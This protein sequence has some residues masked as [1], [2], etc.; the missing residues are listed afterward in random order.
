MTW[1]NPNN[2]PDRR[3][4]IDREQHP[5]WTGRTYPEAEALEWFNALPM[6]QVYGLSDEQ[7]API[8]ASLVK[9]FRAIHFGEQYPDVWQEP[10]QPAPNVLTFE[11]SSSNQPLGSTLPVPFIEQPDYTTLLKRP[12]TG[13]LTN[14]FFRPQTDQLNSPQTVSINQK[15]TNQT[16]KNPT[17]QSNN[18]SNQQKPLKKIS[19]QY[20]ILDLL[21]PS[22]LQ[23]KAKTSNVEMNK[24]G[25]FRGVPPE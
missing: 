14:S 3:R 12:D 18:T 17:R 24:T 11:T 8:A 2:P 25:L 4:S 5:A 21:T 10:K 19:P 1:F 22:V 7:L 6:A 15:N 20:Q 9:E 13:L 16:S 23:A